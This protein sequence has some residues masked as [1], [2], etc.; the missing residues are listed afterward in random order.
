MEHVNKLVAL[1]GNQL[2][3]SADAL[4]P[5]F[6][7]NMAKRFAKEII[8]A[9][10]YVVVVDEEEE[11]EPVGFIELTTFPTMKQ[12][13]EL[14][15]SPYDPSSTYG[16]L[17]YEYVSDFNADVVVEHAIEQ[18]D[19]TLFGT[20]AT[21]E[22]IRDIAFE[23]NGPFL[24]KVMACR[25]RLFKETKGWKTDELFEMGLEDPAIRE[26]WEPVRLRRLVASD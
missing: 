18:L 8:Y 20:G 19:F 10:R 23:N 6:K 2:K 11:L 5:G 22:E 15:Y 21:M 4:M 14:H 16:D 9:K 12:F 26:E 7:R 13:F 25:E 1:F 24:E 17:Y 3:E